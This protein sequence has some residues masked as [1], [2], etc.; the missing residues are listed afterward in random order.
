[1]ALEY[2]APCP[3]CYFTSF[4]AVKIF[5]SQKQELLRGATGKFRKILKLKM[6]GKTAGNLPHGEGKSRT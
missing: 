5:W 2:F 3:Y 4:Y 6:C 1:L